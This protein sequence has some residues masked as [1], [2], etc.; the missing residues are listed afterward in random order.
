MSLASSINNSSGSQNSGLGIALVVAFLVLISIALYTVYRKKRVLEKLAIKRGWQPVDPSDPVV[1][2]FVPYYLR[3]LGYDGIINLAYL[4]Q[5]NGHNIVFCRYSYREKPIEVNMNNQIVSEGQLI[6]YSISGLDVAQMFKPI[7]VLKHHKISN[8]GLHDGLE[9]L[10]LEGDFDK[11]F[12]VFIPKGSEVDALSVLTPD[13]MALMVDM[14]RDFN[15]EINGHAVILSSEED[16]VRAN[17]IDSMLAYMNSLGHKL[18]AK[19]IT[20]TEGADV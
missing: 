1:T 18:S 5:V 6:E 2:D 14:G 9:K 17:K 11:F 19:P 7:L 16:Y 8:V 3:R 12:D 15:L 4:A 20:P 13:I 10:N